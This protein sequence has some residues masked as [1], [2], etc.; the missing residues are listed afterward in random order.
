M[1]ALLV[2]PSQLDKIIKPSLS[3]LSFKKER[4]FRPI[5][6]TTSVPWAVM[7]YAN[8]RVQSQQFGDAG[9]YQAVEMV[10]V[11]LG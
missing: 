11:L 3:A 2:Q 4:D 7:V 5:P 1:L 9:T 10:S 8:L 6:P